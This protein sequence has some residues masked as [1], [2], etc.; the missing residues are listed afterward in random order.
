MRTRKGTTAATAAAVAVALGA[1]GATAEAVELPEGPRLGPGDR[2]LILAPHPDDEVIACAGVVQKALAQNLPLK[3]VFLTHGDN[4]QWSFA[5]YRK[6][7]VLSPRAVRTMGEIRRAEALAAA[8]ILGVR[9]DNLVFL[10]Y[11]DFRTIEIWSRHWGEA[12]A[13]RGM[14][15]R[16]RAV[17]YADAFRP[18]APHKGEEIIRDLRA[19]FTDFRPTQI[20]VS[21]PADHNGDHRA[22]Y[23][24]T[25]VALWTLE[26]RMSPAVHP[27]LVHFRKWP[28]PRG[29]CP[30]VTNSPPGALVSKVR[31]IT[32]PLNAEEI[33]KKLDALRAHRTQYRSSAQYLLSFVRANELFG[34]FETLNIPPAAGTTIETESAGDAPQAES[35]PLLNEDERAVFVGIEERL[36]GLSN[37]NFVVRVKYSRPLTGAVALSLQAFGFRHDRPFETMPKIHVQLD[38]ISHRVMDQ[39]RALPRESCAV[40]RL[41]RQIEVQIPLCVLGDPERILCDSRTRVG[42]IPLDW[43]AWRIVDLRSRLPA[44]AGR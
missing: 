33:T 17:P 9:R 22:L 14:L 30:A 4:N 39:S 6:R 36:M 25:R 10:G 1:L 13:C 35:N 29:L 42:S 31:W 19:I 32:E 26:D 12:P 18:G 3:V 43:V 44:G 21:H 23:L 41:P 11:P 40:T 24:F 16:A 37:S 15:N 38:A 7:P 28:Q 5:V 27:Y 34:D 20:F 8:D 2:I